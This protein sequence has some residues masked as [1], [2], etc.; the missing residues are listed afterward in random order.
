M[1]EKSIPNQPS[2]S[3]TSID[4]GEDGARKN[5][6]KPLPRARIQMERYI[7][8]IIIIW[9]YSFL[10]P[11]VGV[12]YY[13]NLLI[14]PNITQFLHISVVFGDWTLLLLA[15]L[16]PL[17]ILGAFFIRLLLV[18]L[19]SRWMMKFCNWRSPHTELVSAQGIGIKEARA[20]NYYHLRG[21]ILRL[22]KWEVSKSVYPWMVPWAFNFVGANKIGKGTVLEDQFFT[23]EFLETGENVYIGQGSIVSSHAVEGK[24]GA[25]TLKTVKCGKNAVIG[26]FN[27]LP[28]G[29]EL[30]PYTEF[31]PMSAIVKF[32]RVKGFSKYFGL[33]VGKISYKRY[34]RM[35]KIPEQQQELIMNNKILK[36][37][38]KE[39]EQKR[40]L[41]RERKSEQELKQK[42]QGKQQQEQFIQGDDK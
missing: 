30:E 14:I 1:P 11:A 16:T 32:R 2:Q 34:I 7:P 5:S 38:H 12:Y 40:L 33:P 22:L 17:V 20:I 26:P 36:K 18:V 35:L 21:V 6:N 19:F 31:M 42:L 24:Y 29:S 39:R 9:A 8:T 23:Q 37:Q 28:P 13:F 27:I 15:T 10:I 25:I 4:F 3:M 41:E